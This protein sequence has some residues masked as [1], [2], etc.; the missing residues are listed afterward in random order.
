MKEPEPWFE[1]P[2]TG[3]SGAVYDIQFYD[4][5]QQQIY[6]YITPLILSQA[7]G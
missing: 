2:A 6:I 4:E 5:K 7:N 3:D 1:D